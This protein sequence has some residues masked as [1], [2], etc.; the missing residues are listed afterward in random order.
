MAAPMEEDDVDIIDDEQLNALLVFPPDVQQAIEQVSAQ[1][2]PVVQAIGRC[3]WPVCV[4]VSPKQ[5]E[6]RRR[7]NY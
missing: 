1:I 3:F 6:H 5:N 2:S 7:Q 4:V